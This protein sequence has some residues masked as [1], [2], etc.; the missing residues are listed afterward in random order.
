M[1]PLDITQ[2][3]KWFDWAESL[4]MK[5]RPETL[6]PS[7]LSEVGKANLIRTVPN[8]ADTADAADKARGVSVLSLLKRAAIMSPASPWVNSKLVDF[9]ATRL[10]R[11]A[12]M[13]GQL[14]SDIAMDRV[15]SRMLEKLE[16]LQRDYTYMPYRLA[17]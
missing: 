9:S 12:K 2:R 1:T 15:T 3:G 8:L 13:S 7:D 11:L 6:W 17:A 5:L 14:S 4:E 16:Q 10:A